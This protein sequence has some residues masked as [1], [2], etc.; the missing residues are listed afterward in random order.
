MLSVNDKSRLLFPKWNLF[1][2][3]AK[4]KFKI[5]AFDFFP[6]MDCVCNL[7]FVW[8]IFYKSFFFVCP[9]IFIL[10]VT[11]QKEG[12]K[13]RTTK[14]DLN[15]WN[16]ENQNSMLTIRNVNKDKEALSSFYS[17]WTFECG[18]SFM[19]LKQTKI[20]L[21][22]NYCVFDCGTQ[23]SCGWIDPLSFQCDTWF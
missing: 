13:N 23:W 10:Y 20:H 17:D 21:S 5:P 3:W 16:L 7:M 19:H 14:L 12:E 2:C 11:H 18:Q 22:Q 6:S 9:W 4:E 1:G 8:E 15:K